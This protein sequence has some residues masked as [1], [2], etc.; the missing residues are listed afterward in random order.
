M[1]KTK[2]RQYLNKKKIGIYCLGSRRTRDQMFPAHA[3]ELA[4]CKNQNFH[5]Y[6]L[7]NGLTEE[8]IKELYNI[9]P[10]NLTILQFTKP[11]ISN[12]MDKIIFAINQDHEFSIKH[13]EDIFM[14]SESW[15]RLF[16]LADTLDDVNLCATGVVSNGI[17]TVE[18]FLENHTPEIKEELYTDF[19]KIPLIGDGCDYSLLNEQ[20]SRW[21]PEYFYKKIKN[22]NHY[23]KGIHPVR[24]SLTCVKKINQHILKN[25]DTIMTPKDMN[26]VKDSSKYPYFCN[27]IFIIRTSEWKIITE[28]E[29]LYVDGFDEVPLNKYRDQNSKNLVIDI[30]LPILHTMYNWTPDWQYEQNIISQ[31]CKNAINRHKQQEEFEV[32]S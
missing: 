18:L 9:L 1:E 14:V 32:L 27:N 6:L 16:S 19:C 13:D 15:D 30:G 31:I 26:I 24:C 20:Y 7:S 4:K 29:S 5:F 10:N 25:F 8:M 22:F 23:Y 21:D 11:I 3:K 12:Y 2:E 17:P 28:N